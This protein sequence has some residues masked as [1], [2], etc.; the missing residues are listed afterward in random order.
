VLNIIVTCFSKLVLLYDALW[1]AH[2]IHV[3]L[4]I[5]LTKYIIFWIW[6]QAKLH[7]GMQNVRHDY[8]EYEDIQLYFSLKDSLTYTSILIFTILSFTNLPILYYFMPFWN[9]PYRIFTAYSN[10]RNH[11]STLTRNTQPFCFST[12]SQSVTYFLKVCVLSL[13]PYFT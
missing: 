13:F 12:N 8:L 5:Q 9:I 10:K 2:W 7:C 11:H 1:T 3:T 6:N 4:N